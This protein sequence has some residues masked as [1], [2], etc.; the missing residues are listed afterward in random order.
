M[1]NLLDQVCI[2]TKLLC[3]H[4]DTTTKYTIC[5]KLIQSFNRFVLL[6]VTL[7]S[8]KGSLW[9]DILLHAVIDWKISFPRSCINFDK[10]LFDK[11]DSFG[12]KH[13]SEQ[14]LFKN[15]NSKKLAI[16]NFQSICIQK[17]TSKDTDTATRIKKH[18]R[19]C[20]LISSNLV[21]ERISFCNSDPQYLIAFFIGAPEVSASRSK[22]KYKNFSPL[23]RYEHR[24]KWA[25]SHIN[26]HKITFDGRKLKDMTWIRTSVRSKKCASTHFLQI[27]KSPLI[28][29]QEHLER[30]CSV[31]SVF[32]VNF[33]KHILN[34]INPYQY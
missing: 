5:A 13:T 14:K 31:L 33:L 2:N 34:L 10:T 21:E 30:Y 25:T 11:L 24:L 27:Q 3:H 15:K 28:E 26:E 20:V 22:E 32:G 8:K 17:E 16:L 7:F 29:L 23:S 1:K 9:S 19:I 4:W 18:V 6:F 12:I